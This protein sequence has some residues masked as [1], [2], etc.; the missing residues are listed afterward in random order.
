MRGV[1]EEWTPKDASNEIKC[2]SSRGL[3]VFVGFQGVTF[4]LFG[5]TGPLR[6][7][8]LAV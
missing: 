1:D 3:D 8:V 4:Y 6:C 2:K 7:G 5:N